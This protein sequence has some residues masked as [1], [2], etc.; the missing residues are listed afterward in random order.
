MASRWSVPTFPKQSSMAA[1]NDAKS[2]SCFPRRAVFFVNFH[3]RSNRFRSGEYDG[4]YNNSVPNRAASAVT[5]A[6]V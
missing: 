6:H 2:G 1:W 5:A 3:S 4:N